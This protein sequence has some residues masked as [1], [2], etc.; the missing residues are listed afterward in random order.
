LD[1]HSRQFSYGNLA[2]RPVVAGDAG[3][4]E[5]IPFETVYHDSPMPESVQAN[6]KFH[7]Q[8]E[9]VVPGELDL[10]AL[11][12]IWC[13]TSDADEPVAHTGGEKV[14]GEDAPMPGVA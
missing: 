5:S 12:F 10:E 14:C 1:W 13:R 8:A 6:I 2:A 9:V 3:F 4:F 11:R 7:R